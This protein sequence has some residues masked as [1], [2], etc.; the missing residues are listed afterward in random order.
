[1]KYIL[2]TYSGDAVW[3]T[4]KS[5]VE[6][7]QKRILGEFWPHLRGPYQRCGRGPFLGPL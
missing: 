5:L 2:L 1:M 7:E 4:L 3:E 6:E